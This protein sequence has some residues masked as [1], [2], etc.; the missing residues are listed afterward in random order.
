MDMGVLLKEKGEGV[1]GGELDVIDLHELFSLAIII[2]F[3]MF[4]Q[5]LN[6]FNYPDNLH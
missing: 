1:L 5:W 2:L 4:S 6:I 3:N